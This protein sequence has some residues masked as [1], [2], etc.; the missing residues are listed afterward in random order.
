MPPPPARTA[1]SSSR[2]SKTSDPDP[3]DREPTIAIARRRGADPRTCAACFVSAR[4]IRP[5]AAWPR[6]PRCCSSDR[7]HVATC[8]IVSA[9]PHGAGLLLVGFDGVVD[10]TA[11][12][13][14]TGAPSSSCDRAIFPRL[15]DDEFYHHEVVGFAVVTV[16][17][18]ALGDRRRDVLDG[19]ERRLGGA[20]RGARASDPGDRRRGPLHRPRR[21]AHRHR[22]RCRGCSTDAMHIHVLTLFPEMLGSPLGAGVLH[23]ARTAWDPRGRPA[24]AARLRERTASAGRR[25]AVRRRP[26]HGD[27]ARAARRRDR[28]RRRRRSA[29]ARA[30]RRQR[31]AAS[32]RREP[33]ALAAAPVAAARLRPLRG[34]RRAR[35]APSVDEELSVGDYVL[36]GGEPAALVVIDAVVRL[37]SRRPRKRGVAHAT[38][39]S[40]PGLARV[41]AVH[42]PGRVPRRPRA[43]RVALRRPCGGRAVAAHRIAPADPGAAAGPAARPLPSTTP[44]GASS[45]RS[46]G[47]WLTCSSP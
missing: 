2:S 25:H 20:R 30:A 19:A 36:S 9:A 47:R 38:S 22:R 34:C 23:R 1:R 18:R 31:R 10:R 43:G 16:D 8:R 35:D 15:A 46:D 26:G 28:A 11:A 33:T 6:G 24:P 27:D 13:A 7:R 41:S 39:R 21:A 4:I 32:T 12:E 45:A 14:L 40:A 37:A 44:I 3:T 5:R 42:A 17:G 29:A